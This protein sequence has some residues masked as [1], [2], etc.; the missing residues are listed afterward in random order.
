MNIVLFDS[1]ELDAGGIVS[2][3]GRRAAY[4]S[5]VQG[6]EPGGILRVGEIGS[7]M[8]QAELL[9][10]SSEEAVLKVLSLDEHSPETH[11]NLIIALP[12]PQMLKRILQNAA[13][14]GVNRIMFIRSA[15][16]I[17]SYFA[18]PVLAE[19]S[20]REHL[21]LGLEQGVSTKLPVVSVH[22]RFRPFVEDELPALS[23]DST[24]SLLAHTNASSDISE[25][26]LVEGLDSDS[27]I[28][29][30][31]GPEGGWQAHEVEAF[32]NAGFLCC[33]LGARVLRVETAVV[34]L[35]GQIE[36]LRK[37]Q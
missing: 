13:T 36:L 20:I 7:K 24:V 34:S 2:V 15:R 6:A 3:R 21:L 19:E 29:L 12:R 5:E 10:V 35:L 31:I 22:D 32:E 16:V 23:A 37:L 1:N 9:E 27:Q 26:G 18:T 17:K 4:L 11:T 28:T 14:M 8:G 33:G 25:L 30:G